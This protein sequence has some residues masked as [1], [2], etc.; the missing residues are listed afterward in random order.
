[1]NRWPFCLPAAM[2]MSASRASP[3]PLTTQ[4]ITATWM[5]RL[6]FSSAS[7]ASLATAITSTWARPQ[8]G[9][10]MRS[11]PLRSRSRAIP[12]A[13]AGPGLFDRVGGEREADGVADALG[14]QRADA[15][16]ALDQ[17]GR[18]RPGLGD[19]EVQR[20]VEGLRGQPVGRDHE[21]HREALTEIF[22]SVKS[23]SSK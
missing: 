10:A 12:A 17:A 5:G 16:G 18:R 15:G 11:R 21:R 19:A 1:M 6:S 22:T 8:D 14:Q 20:M 13:A 9:Q 7:W 3:G 2:P 23:T 4:P